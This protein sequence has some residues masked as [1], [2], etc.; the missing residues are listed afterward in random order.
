MCSHCTPPAAAAPAKMLGFLCGSFFD[1]R[2]TPA[3]LSPLSPSSPCF[4]T[5]RFAGPG[6]KAL[7]RGACC[8]RASCVTVRANA[9]AHDGVAGESTGS[10]CVREKCVCLGIWCLSVCSGNGFISSRQQFKSVVSPVAAKGTPSG[11]LDQPRHPVV[12]ICP[13][14]AWPFFRFGWARRG[15][16]STAFRVL[17]LCGWVS[18]SHQAFGIGRWRCRERQEP[19]L[20]RCNTPLRRWCE[21][22]HTAGKKNTRGG[23]EEGQTGSR[24]SSSVGGGVV[25]FQVLGV[26]LRVRALQHVSVSAHA[27]CRSCLACRQGFLAVFLSACLKERAVVSGCSACLFLLPCPV[28]YPPPPPPSFRPLPSASP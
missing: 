9:N 23:R 16:A 11:G 3:C 10:V 12:N 2:R 5:K 8:S 18:R 24:G 28:V 27:S 26:E 6:D 17:A 7:M 20:F 22:I 15:R 19:S 21:C 13:R 4:A 1:F 14:L 25:L